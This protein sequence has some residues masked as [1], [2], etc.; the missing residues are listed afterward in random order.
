MNSDLLGEMRSNAGQ[1]AGMPIADGHF[2]GV[3]L[4]DIV[5]YP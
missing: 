5:D 1:F 3:D 2:S 4:M